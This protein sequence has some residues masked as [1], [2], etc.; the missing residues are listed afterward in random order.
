MLM[1]F[2][3]TASFASSLPYLNFMRTLNMG[4][5]VEFACLDSDSLSS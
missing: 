5:I 1:R 4:E 3:P 2:S